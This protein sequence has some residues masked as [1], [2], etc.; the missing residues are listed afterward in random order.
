MNKLHHKN[1]LELLLKNRSNE[2]A[3][4]AHA[5]NFPITENW[6]QTIL[7]FSLQLNGCFVRWVDKENTATIP[8]VYKCFNLMRK[9]G[10][11]QK[12]TDVMKLLDI[13]NK[14][15]E[16]FEIIQKEMDEG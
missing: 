12:V 1:A 7:Q 6:E 4:L 10:K 11:N 16:D 5:L 13:T 8:E 2:F 15:S 14:I 3:E 9:L